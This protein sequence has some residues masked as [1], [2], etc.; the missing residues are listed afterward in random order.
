MTSPEKIKEAYVRLGAK[1]PDSLCVSGGVGPILTGWD[2]VLTLAISSYN[3][4]VCYLGI[5]VGLT[6]YLYEGKHSQFEKDFRYIEELYKSEILR[7]IY[8]MRE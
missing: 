6:S 1:Y 4:N 3:D 5:S 2:E 8:R 7:E